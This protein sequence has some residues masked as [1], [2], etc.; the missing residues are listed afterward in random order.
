MDSL[1]WCVL[2]NAASS[3]HCCPSAEWQLSHLLGLWGKLHLSESRFGGESCRMLLSEHSTT[4]CAF[5]MQ[6]SPWPQEINTGFGFRLYWYL[7]LPRWRWFTWVERNK[8]DFRFGCLGLWVVI[9][10]VFWVF[11]KVFLFVLGVFFFF[12]TVC[13]SLSPAL[14][15]PVCSRADVHLEAFGLPGHFPLSLLV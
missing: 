14:T 7:R 3:C 11:F 12:L 13:C 5:M 6:S 10:V 1:G 9:V 4:L 2:S 15:G 8:L